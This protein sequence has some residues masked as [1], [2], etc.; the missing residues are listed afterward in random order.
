[1]RKTLFLLFELALVAFA[2]WLAHSFEQSIQYLP[3]IIISLPQVDYSMSDLKTLYA[4]FIGIHAFVFLLVNIVSGSW[5]ISSTK[6]SASRIFILMLAYSLSTLSLFLTSSSNFDPNLIVGIALFCAA[7]YLIVSLLGSLSIGLLL[8]IKNLIADIIKRALSISG[9]LI[10]TL[11][12]MP[13]LLAGAFVKDR[14]FANRITQIRMLFSNSQAVQYSLISAIGD[15]R[16][17]QPML[18]KPPA[19]DPDTLYVLQRNGKLY[20]L[21]RKAPSTPELVIDLEKKVGFVEMEN[22]ALGFDF[23]PKF[24]LTGNDSPYLYLYYT[25]VL[26]GKQKNYL[27]RFDISLASPQQRAASETTLMVLNRESSGFHNGGSVEFGGDGFLYLAIGEGVRTPEKKYFSNTLRMGVLRIDVDQRGGDI[28]RPIERS[29]DN[30]ITQNYFIPLDN[31][32]LDNPEILEEYWVLGLRNPF[33][34]SYDA[35]KD[36]WW[37]GDV[38]STKWEEINTLE[39]GKHYQFP[40]IEGTEETG[41]AL[42]S[43]MLGTQQ[44]P[45]YAYFH[46][47]TERAVIGG[48]VYHGSQ[49]PELRSHY[50]FADNYSGNLYRLDETDE[51]PQKVMLAAS[52]DYAQRGISSVSQHPSGDIY[53]TTLGK[54][55]AQTGKL[56]KLVRGQVASDKDSESAETEPPVT[57]E[58]VA[59]IYATNCAR[60]HGPEGKGDGPDQQLLNIPIADFTKPSYRQHRSL[61]EIESIIAEGGSG[62]GLSPMMPPWNVV[63]SEQEIK[64][65]ASFIQSM[66]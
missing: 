39:A 63:L 46:T 35:V 66:Q 23:H 33:R 62:N 42:P 38:G 30:G 24:N 60:C 11:T 2:I 7:L 37:A 43:P 18:V 50:L 32:F 27:S 47:A 19:S 48:V 14:D 20:R 4:Y 5:K 16:F 15:L 58:E 41:K 51:K 28:S 61:L 53:V 22:G 12:L 29:P 8:A 10:I 21:S 49:F 40:F 3:K 52:N 9:A 31:P 56:L 57:L 25:S 65:L 6:S 36:Q 1:M 59:E 64:S 45:V 55:S 54:A 17:Q 44:A 26:E 13:A 34:I